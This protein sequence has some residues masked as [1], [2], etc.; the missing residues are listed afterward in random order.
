ME[1]KY[2]QLETI[3]VISILLLCIKEIVQNLKCLNY[4]LSGI[5]IQNRKPSE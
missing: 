1:Y 2:I 5:F 3:L 4:N